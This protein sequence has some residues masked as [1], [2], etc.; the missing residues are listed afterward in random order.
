MR[1]PTD[2]TR[3]LNPP[4][5]GGIPHRLMDTIDAGLDD[6]AVVIGLAAQ[7]AQLGEAGSPLPEPLLQRLRR[8]ADGGDP[9]ARLM[10]RM[11]V[12]RG[13]APRSALRPDAAAGADASPA[14]EAR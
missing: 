11:L 14:G 9:A 10:L 4:R 7:F 13:K 6:P 1:K 5:P 12:G 3:F 2:T 8:L